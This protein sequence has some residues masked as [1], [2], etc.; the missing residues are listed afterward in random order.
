MITAKNLIDLQ[1]PDVL[2]HNGSQDVNAKVVL[3]PEEATSESLVFVS[4]P[5]QLQKALQVQAPIIVALNK[6]QVPSGT[7]HT[8]FTTTSIQR[9]MADILPLF[10]KKLNRF[11]PGIH[12]ASVIHSTAHIGQNVA[13]GPQTTIGENV[14]I[15]DNAIIGANCT[16]EAGS[17]VGPGCL[18]HPRVFIGTRTHIGARCEIHPHTTIGADGF[19]FTTLA[20]GTHK[21]IPQLGS[22][23]IGD[24]VEIGANCTIDRAALTATKIGSGTKMD[25][26]CHVA[27]NVTIG[28]NCLMAA[29][30]KIAGSSHVG[31]NC[32]FAGDVSV[33]DHVKICDQ[34]IIAGRGVVTNDVTSP[35]RYGGYPLEP[36]Q[37]SLKTI[38]NKTHLTQMRKDLSKVLKHL[39][40]K[41]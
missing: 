32:I 27:H 19:S 10:D 9:A 14:S 28:E 8:F 17:T 13:I 15:G 25:N 26:L 18:I 7:S 31:N 34:V 2:F 1:S 22:V 30:F 4:K 21:K 37:S 41:Q 33:A 16:I 12:S 39:G 36:L 40:L 20:D 23:I 24:N 3:P 35:G 6:L 38:Q 11:I 29:G 5:E